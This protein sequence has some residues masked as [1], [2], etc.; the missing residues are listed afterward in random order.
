MKKI[1]F[2]FAFLFSLTSLGNVQIQG[3]DDGPVNPWPL[4]VDRQ[5]IDINSFGGA[6]FGGGGEDPQWVM[7][8]TPWHEG[9]SYHWELFLKTSPSLRS[10]G[11]VYLKDQY[12]IGLIQGPFLQQ[13][14]IL[15][16]LL[17]GKLRVK[18][19]NQNAPRA[20]VVFVRKTKEF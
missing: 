7:S 14:F 9:R 10:E 4:E 11:L 13:E 18:I 16:Y 8:I 1:L 19:G 15:M 6:W 12:V 5:V 3:P 17:D 2:L 20:E